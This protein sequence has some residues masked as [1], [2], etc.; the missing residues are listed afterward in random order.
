MISFLL[1]LKRLVGGIF[2]SFRSKNFQALFVLTLLFLLSGTIFYVREEGLS[3]VDALYFCVMTL[4]TVGHPD[5][6]PATNLGKMFT[7]AYVL[8]GTGIFIGLILHIAYAIFKE[9]R[10]EEKIEEG[11]EA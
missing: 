2:R 4:S 6:V 11:G 7:I 9:R 1:T 3:I 10:R 8:S 5:F